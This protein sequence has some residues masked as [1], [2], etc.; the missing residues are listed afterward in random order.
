MKPGPVGAV[1][2]KHRARW[3]CDTHAHACT[4]WFPPEPTCPWGWEPEVLSELHVGVHRTPWP[5]PRPQAG[6]RGC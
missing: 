6:Q 3:E 2:S 1:S 4:H 5:G